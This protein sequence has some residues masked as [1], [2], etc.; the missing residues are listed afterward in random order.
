MYVNVSYDNVNKNE[1][2]PFFRRAYFEGNII[3]KNKKG[4]H[5]WIIDNRVPLSESVNIKK[6]SNFFI[7]ILQKT[8]IRQIAAQG[9]AASPL[10]GSIISLSPFPVSLGIIRSSSKGY[11]KNKRIEGTLKSSMPV[12]MI[13]DLMNG[14]TSA[15]NSISV[16]RKEGFSNISLATLMWYD[17]GKGKAKLG[18]NQGNLQYYYGMRI[19]KVGS[20]HTSNK[21][22]I[23]LSRS[24]KNIRQNRR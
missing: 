19:S 10:A 15:S 17:W 23:A 7:R 6:A 12:L 24:R 11:G 18:I 8:G 20:N 13:D 22:K 21:N 3:P 4:M 5:K 2:E 9:V 16:L 14:G 1:F